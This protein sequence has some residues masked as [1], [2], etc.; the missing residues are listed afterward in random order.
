MRFVTF[1]LAC[2]VCGLSVATFTGCSTV[3]V[4]QPAGD[5]AA[6]LDP[7]IWEGTWRGPDNFRGVS[8]IKD[9]VKGLIEFR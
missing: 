2:F 6:K 1:R 3:T 5:K 7:E 4:K 9:P 8:S